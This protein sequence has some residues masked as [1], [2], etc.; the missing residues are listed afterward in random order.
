MDELKFL[1]KG[2]MRSPKSYTLWF[3]RQWAIQKGLVF[4]RNLK[5]VD[6]QILQNELLLCTKM[7]KMDERNFHCWNYRLW[8]VETFLKEHAVRTTENVFE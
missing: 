4:E 8:V 7:L 6:S 2:I 1:V 3:Q 5:Q